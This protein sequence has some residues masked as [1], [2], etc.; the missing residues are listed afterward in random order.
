VFIPL[1]FGVVGFVA[2]V[3]APRSGARLLIPSGAWL[4]FFVADLIRGA[5]NGW[6]ARPTWWGGWIEFSRIL[7]VIG[8]MP[9]LA[10]AIVGL[11]TAVAMVRA[12]V[13]HRRSQTPPAIL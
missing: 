11:L 4:G 2:G 13:E 10:G 8:A 7:L 6:L 1:A 9:A 3:L 12:R 5:A